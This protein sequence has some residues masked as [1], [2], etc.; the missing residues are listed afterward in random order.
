[1]ARVRL[2]RLALVGTSALAACGGSGK[3]VATGWTVADVRGND[4]V[5]R[6]SHGD[7]DDFKRVSAAETAAEVAISVVYRFSFGPCTAAQRFTEHTVRLKE[8]LGSRCLRNPALGPSPEPVPTATPSVFF[9]V[10]P[11]NT[12]R[13]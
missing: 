5:V 7:C 10:H 1:M 4:V 9:P 2:A 3:T 6:V 13:C 12:Q 11:A 8:P